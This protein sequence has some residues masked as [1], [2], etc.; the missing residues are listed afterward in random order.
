MTED[1][2][3]D[4]DLRRLLSDAVSDVEPRD[5]LPDIRSA[6]ATQPNAAPTSKIGLSKAIR[7]KSVVIC[8]LTTVSARVEDV[9]QPANVITMRTQSRS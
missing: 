5:A 3:V 1:D 9:R 8:G 6:I 2:R 4:P 7:L